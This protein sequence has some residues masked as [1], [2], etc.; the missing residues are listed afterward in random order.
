MKIIEAIDGIEAIFITEDK[1]I[2]KTSGVNKEIL[3]LTDE[4]FS[5]GI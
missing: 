5:V 2:Y 4:E 1:K 3:I